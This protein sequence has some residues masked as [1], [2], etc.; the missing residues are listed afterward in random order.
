MKSLALNGEEGRRDYLRIGSCCLAG[1]E[2]VLQRL[3]EDILDYKLPG[4]PGWGLGRGLATHYWKTTYATFP[5]KYD[6]AGRIKRNRLW[7]RKRTLNFGTWNVQG[8][9][10][11]IN[12]I[13]REIKPL[14]IDIMILTETKKKGTGQELIDD[15][16]F[17]WSGVAKTTRAKS[18]VA[19]LLKKKWKKNIINWRE[20]NDRIIQI[21]MDIHGIKL[22]IIGTYAPNN[23]A[24]VI[25]KI[26][27]YD[28]LRETVDKCPDGHELLIMGDFNG[29]VGRRISDET[30]GPWG[31]DKE[32]DNGQRLVDFCKEQE[33]VI[34]NG[35]FKHKDIHKFTWLNPSKNQKSIIDYIIAK[36]REQLKYRM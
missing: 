15:Y 26:N 16:I 28:D 10:G 33:C 32:N 25:D 9:N 2:L 6:T 7:L 11:K 34:M 18:G 27:F 12:E 20:I 21:T 19:V 13:V 3:G 1:W 29:H 23:D 22:D 31:E 14:E 5:M 8:I 4:P 35:K 17:F 24:P 30:V 36:K